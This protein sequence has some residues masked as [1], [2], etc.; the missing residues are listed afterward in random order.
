MV[1][2]L[3]SLVSAGFL[4]TPSYSLAQAPSGA[5]GQ[6]A[7]QRP[8]TQQPQTG[9]AK[10]RGRVT[11]AG[12]GEVIAKARVAV[13]NVDNPRANRSATTDA[14][15]R[16]EFADLPAGRYRII[17]DRTGYVQGA[18]GRTRAN[19]SMAPPPLDLADGA[20]FASADISITKTGVITVRVTDEFGDPVAG[21]I[22][23]P[24]Q[25]AWG[26]DG[27][28]Q[29]S[30]ATPINTRYSPTD[31][32]GETRLYGLPPGEFA[33][34]A[35]VRS[36]GAPGTEVTDTSEGFTTTF[37]PGTISQAEA[38]VVVLGAGE[39]IRV[40]FPMRVSRLSR[41]TGR[42]VDSSG[43]PAAGARILTMVTSGNTTA[44]STVGTVDAQGRFTIAGIP[45]GRHYFAFSLTRGD[46]TETAAVPVTAAGD[47]DDLFVM[48]GVGTPI[49]G[50]VVFEGPRPPPPDERTPLRVGAMRVDP[51]A[52]VALAGGSAGPDEGIVDAEGRFE[53]KA[54]VGDRVFISIPRLASGWMI[55]SVVL[56]GSDI[57]DAP[58]EITGRTRLSG[59]RITV[60]NRL[61]SVTGG[62]ADTRNQPV[63][64][65]VVV[66]LPAEEREPVV[67][68]RLLRTATPDRNGRFTV[69]GLRPGRYMATAVQ[70]IELNRQFS[71]DFQVE[72]RQRATQFTVGDG[73]AVTLDLKLVE[74][75]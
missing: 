19:Q 22:V 38:E 4:I 66:I 41:F 39:E 46:V 61:T 6:I 26:R 7:P 33:L 63:A 34:S 58:L 20:T 9:T 24:Q 43:A 51:Q 10:I 62:V 11:A 40:Q 65:Y 71:P 35:M 2:F 37:Y 27:R 60:T 49:T 67:T 42:A 69:T 1:R 74:G 25:S 44:A 8:S 47:R 36:L 75:L 68:A 72:L 70:F 50:Q 52:R 21:A 55:K 53:T 12:T 5:P 23:D 15:G 31:D 73:Q 59:V 64:S 54:G 29:F 56:D 17:A 28:R 13:I 45:N 3:V 57:T 48:L 14:A 30:A 32:R 16:Y 18:Y